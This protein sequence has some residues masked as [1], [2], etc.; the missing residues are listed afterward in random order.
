MALS[1]GISQK[2]L[3]IGSRKDAFLDLALWYFFFLE[4][5]LVYLSPI[6]SSDSNDESQF[7]R[8]SIISSY[9]VWVKIVLGLGISR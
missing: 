4:T 8:S 6:S 9:N 1:Q 2:E 5:K 3:W 7:S